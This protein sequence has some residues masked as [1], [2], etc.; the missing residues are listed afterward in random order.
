MEISMHKYGSVITEHLILYHVTSR[1]MEISAIH[2]SSL[3]MTEHLTMLTMFNKRSVEISI[4][5]P[6][7]VMTDYPY[8]LPCFWKIY[9]NLNVNVWIKYDQASCILSCKLL[10]ICR[11]MKIS[12]QRSR[13]CN[14]HL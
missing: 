10:D 14:E 1:T 7:S 4:H 3:L 2:M 9:G 5:M 6:G 8:I 11:S 12:I 13:I